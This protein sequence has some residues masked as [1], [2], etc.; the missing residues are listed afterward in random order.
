MSAICA[1]R[2]NENRW[3]VLTLFGLLTNR[4][5]ILRFYFSPKCRVK[6]VDKKKNVIINGVLEA[7]LKA[8]PNK[9]PTLND[10]DTPKRKMRAT[11]NDNLEVCYLTKTKDN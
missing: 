3:K 7:Y 8:H 2:F 11:T 6:V 4:F 1:D 9:R 10:V 5:K